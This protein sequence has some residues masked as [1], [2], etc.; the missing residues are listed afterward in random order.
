MN[1]F[2]VLLL[3]LV[4][5]KGIDEVERLACSGFDCRKSLDGAITA[6][7]GSWDGNSTDLLVSGTQALRLSYFS[8]SLLFTLCIYQSWGQLKLV[9][10]AVEFTA[11]FFCISGEASNI[12]DFLH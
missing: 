9:H 3:K 4:G 12:V 8:C 7:A 2:S 5:I 10:V 6:N 1:I 11:S